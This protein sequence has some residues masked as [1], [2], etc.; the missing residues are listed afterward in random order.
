MDDGFFKPNYLAG[1]YVQR[2]AHLRKA[3]DSA[4]LLGGDN[5]RFLPFLDVKACLNKESKPLFV[6]PDNAAPILASAQHCVFLGNYEKTNI[7]ALD[8]DASHKKMLFDLGAVSFVGLRTAAF[9]VQRNPAGL[10]AYASAMIKWHRRSHFCGNCGEETQA[11]QSGHVRECNVCDIQHFPRLDPAIIVLVTDGERCLLGRQSNWDPGRYS[12]IAGFVEPG[13][14]LEDAVAREV[15]EETGVTTCNIR[16][17]S[18]QPWP[19]PS[20]LMLGFFSEA[21]SLN[22]KLIDDELEDAQWF[23]KQDIKQG[24]P[25]LPFP[26]SISFRLVEDWFNQGEEEKLRTIM[27]KDPLKGD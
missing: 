15:L 17:H 19:F 27:Q 24:K 22:I 12:T 16:Y 23:S 25:L 21:A 8:L 7:F 1:A 20:S 14:S 26:V 5:I 4:E 9:Q 10:L 3:W 18:S 13:E 11:T 6:S 2:D